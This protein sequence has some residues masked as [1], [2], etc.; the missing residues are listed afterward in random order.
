MT[1]TGGR[2][3]MLSRLEYHF[4]LLFFFFLKESDY[5]VIESVV[6]VAVDVSQTLRRFDTAALSKGVSCSRCFP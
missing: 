1:D 2:A 6:C 3:M 4:F 5:I